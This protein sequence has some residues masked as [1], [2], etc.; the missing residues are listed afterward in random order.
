MSHISDLRSQIS[1]LR[2]QISDHRSQITYHK[3]SRSCSN[4]YFCYSFLYI[5][6]WAQS[7]RRCECRF[8]NF[9]LFVFLWHFN[10]Q[11]SNDWK[12]LPSHWWKFCQVRPNKSIIL[13]IRQCRKKMSPKLSIHRVYIFKVMQLLPFIDVRQLA[14]SK[15]VAIG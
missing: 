9:A 6:H 12:I 15:L 8:P 1:D 10:N 13:T 2:S 3:I 4:K 11:P 7:T 14:T 5:V